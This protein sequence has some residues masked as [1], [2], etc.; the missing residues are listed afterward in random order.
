MSVTRSN[1]PRARTGITAI[2]SAWAMSLPSMRRL[3]SNRSMTA[4]TSR[5]NSTYGTNSATVVNARFVA[6]CV[7]L[8]TKSG[9]A[10]MVNEPPSWET[11]CPLK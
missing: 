10:K 2:T 11:A 9:N 7:S 4:P 6:E 8:N 3:R 5:P 1:P